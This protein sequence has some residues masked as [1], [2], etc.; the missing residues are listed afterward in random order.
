M[1]V[2]NCSLSFDKAA[3]EKGRWEVCSSYFD[4]SVFFGGRR[5]GQEDVGGVF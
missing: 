1:S 4:F 3:L 5:G 2:K